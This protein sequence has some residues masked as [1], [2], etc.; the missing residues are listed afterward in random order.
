MNDGIKWN[1]KPIGDG[2]ARIV[3]ET[4]SKL[5]TLE[6]YRKYIEGLFGLSK[7]NN[8]RKLI[9]ENNSAFIGDNILLAQELSKMQYKEVVF[10]TPD[11][12]EVVNAENFEEVFNSLRTKKSDAKVQVNNLEA[13]EHSIRELFERG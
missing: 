1:L 6:D 10:S 13:I 9:D 11:G 7:S 5:P 4:F 3:V 8:S 12:D 2:K